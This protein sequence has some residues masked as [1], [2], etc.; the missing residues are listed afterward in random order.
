MKVQRFPG[1][2]LYTSD[3]GTI[4]LFNHEGVSPRKNYGRPM[5]KQ[6]RRGLN[7]RGKLRS[8]GL[9]KCGHHSNPRPKR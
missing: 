8:A 1:F 6:S 4:M 7:E 5:K 9:N 2:D 3:E